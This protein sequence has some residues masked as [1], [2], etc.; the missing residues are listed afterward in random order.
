MSP[1][2]WTLCLVREF[3]VG[4]AIPFSEAEQSLDCFQYLSMVR[5]EQK[6]RFRHPMGSHGVQALTRYPVPPI[7]ERLWNWQ[8]SGRS[9]MARS[10]R[11]L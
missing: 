2:E 4:E 8:G 1:V 11:K 3:G 10:A 9:S 5:V 7:G 6:V